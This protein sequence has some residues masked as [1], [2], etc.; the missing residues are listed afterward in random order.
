MSRKQG[1]RP[2]APIRRFLMHASIPVLASA[3]GAGSVWHDHRFWIGSLGP[4]KSKISRLHNQ[5]T[6][7]RAVHADLSAYER[8]KYPTIHMQTYQQNQ[9]KTS[10]SI[11]TA[12]TPPSLSV[13]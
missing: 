5:R 13:P 1:F 12:T 2:A 4:K 11:I 6:W 10:H 9:T 7:F 8:H 3:V